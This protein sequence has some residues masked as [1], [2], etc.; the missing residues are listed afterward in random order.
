VAEIDEAG[1]LTEDER[2]RY[3][4][5]PGDEEGNAHEFYRTRPVTVSK[6]KPVAAGTR[7]TEAS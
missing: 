4:G 7:W 3:E 5:K 6:A 1:D 2:L